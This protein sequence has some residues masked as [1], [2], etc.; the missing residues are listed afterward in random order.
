MTARMCVECSPGGAH[1][2]FKTALEYQTHREL[3]HG[4]VF[5]GP[6]EEEGMDSEQRAG[7]FRVMDMKLDDMAERL[8]A[9]PGNESLSALSATVKDLHAQNAQLN[10]WLTALDSNTTAVHGDIFKQL[11][12][13][14]STLADLFARLA[15]VEAAVKVLINDG[16]S[17]VDPLRPKEG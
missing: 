12:E 8:K 1:P 4:E 14:A 3:A 11:A 5:P 6:P 17:Q 9:A 10:V 15:S 7:R 2:E 13:W 16:K